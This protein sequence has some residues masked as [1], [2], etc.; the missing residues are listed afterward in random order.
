MEGRMPD[1]FQEQVAALRRAQ[2]LD[3][4]TTVFA[5][6]G[7]HRTTI[8]DVAKAAGVADGTI[9]NYFE[10]KTALLLG[11]LDRLNESDRRE[12]D[13]SQ[14]GAMDVRQFFRSY[15]RHRMDT[16]GEQGLQVLRVVLSEMLVNAELRQI[17][18][19]RIVA[20]SFALAEPHAQRLVQAGTLR[21]NDVPMMMRAL[22]GMFLGLIVLRLLGD[23][24][25]E[26]KWDTLPDL[27]TTL[28]LDGLLP[29]EGGDRGTTH[30]C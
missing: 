17:Y 25:L 7:F 11:I 15:F 12:S 18:V 27:L 16:I 1:S 5:A 24:Q 2:I 19:E 29:S 28:L 23:P 20:P 4:A 9:Y 22:S 14:L 8:R 21:A 26:A 3:A 13:L 30:E 10:N 6:Q